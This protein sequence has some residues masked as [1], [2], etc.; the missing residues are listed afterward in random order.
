MLKENPAMTASVIPFPSRRAPALTPAQRETL[1]AWQGY[2][3]A[4]VRYVV[5]SSEDAEEA[6][7][8]TLRGATDPLGEPGPRWWLM[9]TMDSAGIVVGDSLAPSWGGRFGSIEEAL[10]AID[11]VAEAEWDQRVA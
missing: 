6:V 2:R 8:F 3:R 4:W 9:R 7:G 10:A 1:A 11:A 5:E